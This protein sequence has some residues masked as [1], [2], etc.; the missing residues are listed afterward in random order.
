LHC[1]SYHHLGEAKK[2]RLRPLAAPFLRANLTGI[3]LEEAARA[4]EREGIRVVLYD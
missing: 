4:F 2:S 3:E 1:L